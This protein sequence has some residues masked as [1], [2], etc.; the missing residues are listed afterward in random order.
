MA[1]G[2]R[3]RHLIRNGGFIRYAGAMD[4][5]RF[6]ARYQ[7]GRILPT[8]VSAAIDIAAPASRVWSILTDFERYP[9]WNP[10]TV[11]VE[12]SL[13]IGEPVVMD[14]RLPGKR[15]SVR[16]EWVNHVD[17]GRAFA[18]GMHM[19]RPGWLTANRHQRVEPRGEGRCRYETS[20]DMSGW[21]VPVVMAFYGRSMRLGFESVARAL[22][23]RA[24]APA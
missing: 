8:S 13:A 23:Q 1:G 7:Q 22:K 21:L 10:F 15:P 16:T 2:G 5:A 6:R 18:W 11:S 24:E 19:V 3:R 4:E 14:V 17:E 12:T 20:D 9:E